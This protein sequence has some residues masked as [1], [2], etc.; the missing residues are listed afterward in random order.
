LKFGAGNARVGEPIG[1]AVSRRYAISWK[2]QEL[3][4]TE[5]AKLRWVERRT[6]DDLVKHFNVGRAFLVAEL[7][8]IKANPDLVRDGAARRLVKLK[9]KRFFGK[10][11]V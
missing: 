10:A 3:D 2:R 6:V 4:L 1:A 5:L 8:R 9:E 11:Q 7:G